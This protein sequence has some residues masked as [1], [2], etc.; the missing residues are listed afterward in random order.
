MNRPHFRELFQIRIQMGQRFFNVHIPIQVDIR[1]FRTVIGLMEADKIFLGQFWNRRRKSARF[2]P[3]GGVRKQNFLS[4]IFQIGIRRRIHA[5]H[6]IVDNTVV[7]QRIIGIF[8]FVMPSFL[9]QGKFV[10]INQR[11][12]HRIQIHIHQI[13]KIFVVAAGHRVHGLIRIR[14]G[15]QKSIK[16]TLHQFH[17]RFL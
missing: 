13:V 3:V 11:I 16:G 10:F 2:K 14:H 5:F 17:K 6:L 7:L 12:K 8:Q 15:I 1:I 9:L 4:V